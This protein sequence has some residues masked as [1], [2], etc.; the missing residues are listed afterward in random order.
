MPGGI[1]APKSEVPRSK[2]LRSRALRSRALRS[3]AL[4]PDLK[5]LDLDLTEVSKTIDLTSKTIDLTGASNAIPGT[6][7]GPVPIPGTDKG[8]RRRLWQPF[9]VTGDVIS[10]AVSFAVGAI[11]RQ[12]FG[13]SEGPSFLSSLERELPFIPLF[14]MAMALYGLYQRDRRR[15]RSTSFLDIGPRGHALA[16]GAIGTVMASAGVARLAGGEKIGWVEVIFMSLPATALLPLSRALT[17][18]ALRRGGTNRARVVIV[19]SG[20]VAASLALRLARC[21]DIELVGFVDDKPHVVAAGTLGAVPLGTILD[22]PRVCDEKAV[23]RVLVA[24]SQS[25]PAW[26]A[27]TLRKLPPHVRISVVPRLF[28]LVTWQSKIEDLHGLTVMDVAPP[29][30]GPI[31]RATKRSL[32]IAFSAG[33]L[34]ALSPLLLVIAIAIKTTSPGPVFF[35]QD[36]VGYKGKIFRITK[37]RTMEEGADEAKIDLRDRNDVDGP[38]FKLHDDPRVTRLGRFLRSTSLDELPQL[39]NVLIGNM[40]LIGPRPF[41]PNECAGID[42]WAARRFDVRPGMTGLWQISGRNDLPFEELRQL[43]YAYVASWSLWWDLKILWH[44][45][46]SVIRRQGAY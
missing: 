35:R 14:I 34:I 8:V 5:G 46:A 17:S 44:T 13:P 42:G 28:E 31:S 12:P 19:G 6:I 10:L 4:E 43:D 7:S 16:L 15:L 1:T 45:P 2:T 39:I 27:E 29:R 21:A 3:N 30:L 41:V 36:R 37:F 40:S 23:D 32:D 11:A 9:V 38:L 18:L 33:S 24:F 20:S 22:L 26:V 25:S